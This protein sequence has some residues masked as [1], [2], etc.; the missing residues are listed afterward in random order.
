MNVQSGMT[1]AH[2]KLSV[3]GF[4]RWAEDRH[5]KYELVDGVPRVQRR[6]KRSHSL[7]AGNVAFAL[8]S[9]LDRHRYAVHQ[10]NFAVLTG[11]TSIRFADVLVEPSGASLDERTTDKAVLL[12]EVLSPSTMH[13][14]FGPKAREYLALPALDTYLIID[15]EARQAWQWSRGS[16][17]SWPAEPLQVR[18]EDGVITLT[19]IDVTLRFA[20]IYRGVR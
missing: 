18:D 2:A 11:P 13:I 7:I 16:D 14:D 20:D 6:V 3:D 9:A 12:V 10:G 8:Q 1:D 5:E 4:F 17:G 15:A 19:A